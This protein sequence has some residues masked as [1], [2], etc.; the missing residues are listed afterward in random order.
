LEVPTGRRESD[1][2]QG[3]VVE[4]SGTVRVRQAKE[5]VRKGTAVGGCC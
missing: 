1:G 5:R 4:E 3:L 2:G